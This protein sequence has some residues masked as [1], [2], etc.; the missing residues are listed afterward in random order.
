MYPIRTHC[1]PRPSHSA[2]VGVLFRLVQDAQTP[3]QVQQMFD[4]GV[5]DAITKCV[6]AH[7]TRGA[8]QVR[9]GLDGAVQSNQ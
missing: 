9:E 3:E 2:A 1:D 5:T 4:D 7:P 8:L 6:T